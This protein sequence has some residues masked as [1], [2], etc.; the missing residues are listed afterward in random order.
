MVFVEPEQVTSIYDYLTTLTAK[1]R[2]ELALEINY[3]H[4]YFNLL[5]STKKNLSEVLASL[6][7]MSDFNKTPS[8][9]GA[10]VT[11]KM[12]DAHIDELRA[13]ALEQGKQ[14]KKNKRKSA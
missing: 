2:E 9:S 5:V 11:K 1:E 13:M 6:I 14:R 12:L 3:S 8:K 7:W 4:A 10:K